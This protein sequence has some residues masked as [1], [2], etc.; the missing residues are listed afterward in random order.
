MIASG[1]KS[2]AGS[3]SLLGYRVRGRDSLHFYVRAID[4]RRR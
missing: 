1:E 2:T 3:V 4:A